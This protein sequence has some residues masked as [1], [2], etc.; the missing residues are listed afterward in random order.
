MITFLK[1][2][3]FQTH[4]IAFTLMVLASIGLYFAANAGVTGLIWALLGVFALAN[5]LAI[6]VR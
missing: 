4:L 1:E 3:K 2:H 6:L 5:L